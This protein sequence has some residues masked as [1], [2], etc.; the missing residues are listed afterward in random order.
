MNKKNQIFNK[1]FMTIL[2]ILIQKI[3]LSFKLQIVINKILKRM[4]TNLK[5]KKIVKSLFIFKFLF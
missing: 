2:H 1:I 3:N 5:N 4:I